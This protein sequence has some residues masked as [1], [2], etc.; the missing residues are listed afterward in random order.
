MGSNRRLK[1]EAALRLFPNY[2][3]EVAGT[4]WCIILLYYFQMHRNI[5]YSYVVANIYSLS[6]VI[7]AGGGNL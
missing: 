7:L 6:L 3:K 4:V 1:E 5:P 2:L